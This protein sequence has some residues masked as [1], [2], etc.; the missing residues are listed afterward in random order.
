MPKGPGKGNTNNP[1]G[2][3]KGAVMKPTRMLRNM[4]TDFVEKDFNKIV[5]DISK[6]DPKDRVRCYIDLL[7][8]A[9][10]RLQATALT[11][12][13]GN[14]VPAFKVVFT[15]AITGNSK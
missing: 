7:Q 5:S 15:D 1:K 2:K 14:S 13:E 9:L 3:P 10:P 4:I 11:D 8:F 6:L 12:G